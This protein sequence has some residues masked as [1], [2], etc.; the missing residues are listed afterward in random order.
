MLSNP[1][2]VA[3]PLPHQ[4]G[5]AEFILQKKYI[6]DASAMGTGKSLSALLAFTLM[7]QQDTFASMLV[8]CPPGLVNNWCAEVTKHTTLTVCK[9]FK[10]PNWAADIYI[11]PYTQLKHGATLFHNST[12]VIADEAHYL[13]NL[14][15]QR[16]KL[17]HSLMAKHPPGYFT[18]ASG[19]PIKGRVP[20]CY[21][22]LRL[23][24]HGPNL[25]KIKD[26]YRSYYVFCDHFCHKKETAF[27][28][29]YEGIKNK[30]VAELK[31][32]ILPF[33]VKHSADVLNLPELTESEVV[34]SYEDNPE[35]QAAFDRF[36]Q[37]GVGA[38]IT[39]KRD[40]A[41]ATAKLTSDYIR[42]SLEQDCGPI[43]VFSDHVKPL[44]MMAEAL[45]EFRIGIIDGSTPMNNR[46]PYVDALNSGN[47]DILFGTFGAM[48][49]GYNMTGANLMILNDPP[50]I[51]SDLEQAK[52][53]IHRKGQEKVCRIV[54]VIGSKVV[55]TIYKA[56][57]S[58]QKT[59]QKVMGV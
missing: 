28:S 1:Y 11:L 7:K 24:D 42:E 27:G 16:T 10:S 17:F 26:A 23:W 14:D 25:P 34:V 13:K 57:S 58:K 40:S 29:K 5:T 3:T 33:T 48:S 22:M 35:L 8:V 2:L 31:S 37:H 52:K 46:Q 49:S 4:F 12:F 18:Y 6:L 30:H 41:V 9:N 20:E 47:L 32:Y 39:V 43:V 45:S 53:R 15:A 21:S 19:T 36:T 38:E 54:K 51:P 50:W 56:V 55:E 59:V 44:Q